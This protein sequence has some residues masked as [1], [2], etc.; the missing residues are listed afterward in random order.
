MSGNPFSGETR[1]QNALDAPFRWNQT[2]PDLH[3]NQL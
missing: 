3:D 1:T 2:E